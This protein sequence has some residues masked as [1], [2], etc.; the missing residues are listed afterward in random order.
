MDVGIYSAYYSRIP[1]HWFSHLKKQFPGK[2]AIDT[3]KWGQHS[4]HY[5]TFLC[6]FFLWAHHISIMSLINTSYLVYTELLD[7]YLIKIYLTKPFRHE[8]KQVP[9]SKVKLLFKHFASNW[10][11]VYKYFYQPSNQFEWTQAIKLRSDWHTYSGN[12]LCGGPFEEESGPS[13]TR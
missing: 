8:K 9:D 10:G 5:N 1:H 11:K 7:S 12:K 6:A 4:V 13:L 2:L 3:E